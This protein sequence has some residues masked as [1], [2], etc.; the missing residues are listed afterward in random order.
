[1][2]RAKSSNIYYSE[3]IKMQNNITIRNKL[4]S[5]CQTKNKAKGKFH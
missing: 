2:Y 1:M 3:I 5:E 4:H